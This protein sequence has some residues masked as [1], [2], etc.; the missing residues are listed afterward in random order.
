MQVSISE[1]LP[2]SLDIL[3]YKQESALSDS[4]NTRGGNGNRV[5]HKPLCFGPVELPSDP[6]VTQRLECHPYKVEVGGPNPPARTKRQEYLR[7]YQRAWM[8]RRRR[9]WLLQNGPC[10]QCGS[11]DSLEIHHRDPKQKVTHLVWSCRQAVRDAE[12]AKCAVLCRA[13]HTEIT[14]IDTTTRLI[15]APRMSRVGSSGV[16][17]VIWS[18]QKRAWR[19]EFRGQ[20]YAAH[21]GFFHNLCTAIRA[22]NAYRAAVRKQF[23]SQEVSSAIA[24]RSAYQAELSFAG[25]AL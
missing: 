21:L 20:K 5:E 16:S 12:L 1:R 24:C 22:A 6:G 10:A 18:K 23:D 17:N 2:K 13:C 19:G 14:R 15:Y 25:G 8:A 9:E 11:S 3:P 4:T 7:N